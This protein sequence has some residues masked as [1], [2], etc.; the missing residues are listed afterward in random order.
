MELLKPTNCGEC[1]HLADCGGMEGQLSLTGGCFSHC[2]PVC[3]ARGC[4]QACPFREEDYVLKQMEVGGEDYWPPVDLR[5]PNFEELPIYIPAIRHGYGRVAPFKAPQNL[6]VLSLYDVLQHS[7][8]M[9]GNG[10]FSSDP[11]LALR[12]RFKLEAEAEIIVTSTGFDP[13]L[14]A[15]FANYGSAKI[16]KTLAS[17]RLA[18]MSPPNYSLFRSTANA[19]IVRTDVRWNL[20]RI[21]R[22]CADLSADGVPV[23]PHLNAMTAKDWDDW[24]RFFAERPQLKFVAIEFQTGLR[25]AA[26]AALT[27]RRFAQLQETIGRPLHP[28][29][30]GGVQFRNE[31]AGIFKNFTFVNSDP[32]MKALHRHVVDLDHDLST[33]WIKEATDRGQPADDHL[34]LNV[35]NYIQRLSGSMKTAPEESRRPQDF[36]DLA[37]RNG[38]RDRLLADNYTRFRRGLPL[39]ELSA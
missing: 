13:K 12:Q 29:F 21:W 38:W 32:F 34:R 8:L 36:W 7:G 23:I 2:G 10:G 37:M 18:A 28:I 33:R 39:A 3:I 11:A 25:K 16:G 35:Q 31:I 30:I 9:R 14:E 6:V 27:L 5:G 15:F 1:G 24:T 4:D 20:K 26:A 19:P 17:L 22:A